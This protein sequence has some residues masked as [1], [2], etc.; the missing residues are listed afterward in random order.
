MSE[1]ETTGTLDLNE[2]ISELV[3]VYWKEKC[4]RA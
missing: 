1:P 4:L 3:H 2:V